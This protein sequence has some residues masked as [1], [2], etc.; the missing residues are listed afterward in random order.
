V[1][2]WAVASLAA[3]SSTSVQLVVTATQTITNGAYRATADGNLSAVGEAP[4]VTFVGQPV[5]KYYYFGSQR[6]AMR[7][8]DAVYYLHGDHLGSTS[9]TTDANGTIVAHSRYLPYGQERWTDGA[10]QT[11]FTFTGQRNERGF[12]L[13]DYTARYYDPYLN[14][15]VSADSIVPQP[16]DPQNLNRYSYTRNNPVLYTDPSGHC[17]P[18]VNCPGMISGVEH[19]GEAPPGGE[20]Y[21]Q[22]LV[23]LIRWTEQMQAETGGMLGW[24]LTQQTAAIELNSFV[25]KDPEV[26][27]DLLWQEIG[28][29]AAITGVKLAQGMADFLLT[30]TGSLINAITKANIEGGT[31]NVPIPRTGPKGIGY[32]LRVGKFCQI[33]DFTQ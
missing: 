2:T 5:T 3:D 31:S 15:W 7:K 16:G 27:N 33:R 26:L 32:K 17:I 14:R 23:R 9:L 21:A 13:V 22:Y 30:G 20:E 11:D 10:A 25:M 18:G 24:H 4:A 19:P 12:G 28:Q 1:V 29:G 6:V 8:G